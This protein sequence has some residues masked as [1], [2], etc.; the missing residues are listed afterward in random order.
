M[1]EPSADMCDEDGLSRPGTP[2]PLQQGS[3]MATDISLKSSTSVSSTRTRLN[4][5]SWEPSDCAPRP[6]AVDEDQL[7]RLDGGSDDSSSSP[8]S[9][10]NWDEFF[11][12]KNTREHE[13]RRSWASPDAFDLPQVSAMRAGN[14]VFCFTWFRTHTPLRAPQACQDR[15][16]VADALESD[17]ASIQNPK[18]SDWPHGGQ[19]D[20]KVKSI[21][22]ELPRT[23]SSARDPHFSDAS[24]EDSIG[25]AYQEHSSGNHSSSDASDDGDH[26]D[27]S[28]GAG[29]EG[30]GSGDESGDGLQNEDGMDA[31]NTSRYRSDS[32]EDDA[33]SKGSDE[34]FDYFLSVADRMKSYSQIN[35]NQL[36]SSGQSLNSSFP[37]E[38]FPDEKPKPGRSGPL[39][40]KDRILSTE[41]WQARKRLDV[42]RKVPAVDI[43][44]K[45]YSE[46]GIHHKRPL[47]PSKEP[48][49]SCQVAAGTPCALAESEKQ[50]RDEFS[51]IPAL[52]R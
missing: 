51:A 8:S 26:G 29:E 32:D 44:L 13:R 14:L 6:A 9:S 12:R 22:S 46:V 38:V 52:C 3:F 31:E 15:R 50:F 37:V 42:L 34:L 45:G 48:K 24:S 27:L 40:P 25:D 19:A 36:S 28:G 41:T 30:E 49:P 21:N 10:G 43:L 23:F 33:S 20:G 16:K 35:P 1:A 5:V 17:A 39:V 18:M 47:V 7:G 4:V 11:S 2:P